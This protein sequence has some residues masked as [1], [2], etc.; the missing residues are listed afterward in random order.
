MLEFADEDRVAQ[1]KIWSRGIESGFD[2]QRASDL[3][4]LFETFLEICFANDFDSAFG[5]VG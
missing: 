5:N 1:V 3:E 2:A 4:R